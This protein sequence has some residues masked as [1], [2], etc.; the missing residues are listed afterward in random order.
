MVSRDIDWAV[1]PYFAVTVRSSVTKG[2]DY[3][4]TPSVQIVDFF[5]PGYVT[6]SLGFLYTEGSVFSTRLGLAVQQTFAKKFTGYT[7]D[8][9]TLNEIEDFKFDT[10]L[11]SVSELKYDFATNMSYSSFLRLFSRFNQLDVW[12]I[13]WDNN[14]AAKVNDYISVNLNVVLVHEISQSRKTQL[15]EALQLGIIYTIF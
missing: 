3:T 11:E 14:I 4:V 6:E 7:D 2:Y 12:D 13:R 1:D 8:L 15:K 9:E 10:G 5:D